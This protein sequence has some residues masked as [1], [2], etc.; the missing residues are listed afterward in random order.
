VYHAIRF[1]LHFYEAIDLFIPQFL[2]ANITF[3]HSS[4][5][6]I[7]KDSMLIWKHEIAT[8]IRIEFSIADEALV[9]INGIGIPNQK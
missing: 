9:Y 3:R 5:L 6:T 7:N 1:G 4:P 2:G 8:V